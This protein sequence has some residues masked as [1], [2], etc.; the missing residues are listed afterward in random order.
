MPTYELTACIACGSSDSTELAGPEAMREEMEALWA[1]HER[2][3]RPGAPPAPLAD[4]VAFSQHPPLR[5][6]RCTGCGL[7]YRNPIERTESLARAYAE[8]AP[9]HG[10]FQALHATQRDAYRAQA[11]RLT[12]IVGRRGTGIEVGSYVAGFLA[13]ARDEGWRFT[14]V[15]VNAD[16][17]AFARNLGFEARVG[18]IEDDEGRH[19]PVDVVAFWNCFDQLADPAQ[20]LRAAVERLAPNGWIAIRVPNGAFYAALRPLLDS[21]FAWGARLLLAHN[22]LLGF[23]YRFGFTPGSLGRLASRCGLQVHAV[24]GDT[25]VPI[26]DRWTRPWAAVEE[27]AVKRVLSLASRMGAGAPWFELYARGE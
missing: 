15:D 20:S 2:R 24:H 10:T 12:R 8:T 18:T 25:L 26:A 19:A 16:A 5:L 22:N 11:K 17:V 3:L 1:F 27:R 23:P 9:P 21:P 7:V 13:A 4:R 14:G 6:A